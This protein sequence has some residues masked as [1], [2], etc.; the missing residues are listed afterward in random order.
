[1][2]MKLPTCNPNLTTAN[3]H[4]LL[5]HLWL[6]LDMCIMS[7]TH[8]LTMALPHGSPLWVRV[9]EPTPQDI[10]SRSENIPI[11][12][13]TYRSMSTKLMYQ[14]IHVHLLDVCI[15][16]SVNLSQYDRMCDRHVNACTYRSTCMYMYNVIS[17]RMDIHS[18]HSR[19]ACGA[20]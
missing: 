18:A 11:V 4:T 8:L 12:T 7:C 17:K 9:H 1:M 3:L 14:Y 2:E 10:I 5:H 16:Y 6:M 13:Q 15:I 19:A 20:K